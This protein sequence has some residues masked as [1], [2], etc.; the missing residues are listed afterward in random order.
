MAQ[1]FAISSR[2]EAVAYLKHN[3][4]G[5]RLKEC[6]ALVNAVDGCS[7]LE[8]LG[9]MSLTNCAAVGKVR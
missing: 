4:L 2:E 1:R 7:I 3:V 8:S 9:S 6:T 5:V